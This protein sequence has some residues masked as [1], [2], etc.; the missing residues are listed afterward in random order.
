MLAPSTVYDIDGLSAVKITTPPLEAQIVGGANDDE[1]V[2]GWDSRLVRREAM[3]RNPQRGAVF[4]A[5]GNADG[6]GLLA[7]DFSRPRAFWARR[8]DDGAAAAAVRTCRNLLQSD[9]LLALAA[10]ELPG[11]AAL[12]AGS[13]IRALLGARPTAILADCR[14]GDMNCLLAAM[15]DSLQRDGD[16]DLNVLA[17]RGLRPPL[18]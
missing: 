12:R 9:A 1:E 10:H 6:E 11:A 3:A 8:I 2:A 13:R 15:E 7:H 16:D 17:A 14:T 4:R 18:L 5:Y